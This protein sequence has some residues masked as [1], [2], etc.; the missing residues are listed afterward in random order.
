MVL[1]EVNHGCTI[2][3]VINQSDTFRM[4]KVSPEKI[5]TKKREGVTCISIEFDIADHFSKIT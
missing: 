1:K 2:K 3:N 4:Q 5:F